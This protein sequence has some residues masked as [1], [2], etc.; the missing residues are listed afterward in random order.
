MKKSELTHKRQV[1]A[2]LELRGLS[3]KAFQF[4]SQ[5][6]PLTF[7][8][9]DDGTFTMTGAIGDREGMT[10]KDIEE[11]LEDWADSIAEDEEDEDDE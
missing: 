1:A 5:T 7:Y 10:L 6:D 3:D 9:M 8:L 2:E 11:Y 4:Y